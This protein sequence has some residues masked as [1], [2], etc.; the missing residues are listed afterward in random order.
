[1]IEP[2]AHLKK[3]YRVIDRRDS[4][5]GFVRLDRNERT[6]G[7]PEEVL[8]E[9]WA[10][11]TPDFFTAYPQ[12]EPFY[13][14]LAEWLKVD[15]DNLLLSSGSDTAIRHVFETYVEAG[16]EVVMVLPSYDMYPVFCTMYDGIKREIN[17][18]SGFELPINDILNAI[19]PKTKLVALINPN[20]PIIRGYS[21]EELIE[22]I[23]KS[24]RNNAI[25]LIDEAY[26]H[27]CPYTALPLIEKY[28]N[29]VITRT[30]SKAFGIAGLRLGYIISCA[31]NIENMLKVKQTFEVDSFALEVGKYLLEHDSIMKE[32]VAKID[33]G[34]DYLLKELENMSLQTFGGKSNLLLVKLP[35]SV[36][37]DVIVEKLKSKGYLVRGKFNEPPLA[38]NHF[39][40][41]TLGPKEQM[42]GF[43]KALKEV[44]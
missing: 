36:G 32:Y 43:I 33:E 40:R 20:Q 39:I 19:N 25:V 13:L 21:E 26:Y 22:I 9:I 42:A 24:Q 28:D 6:T 7:F 2:R 34:R 38:T 44:Y 11:I 16:D 31:G 4:R 17:F 23:K 15:R 3:V 5:L 37:A 35:D 8:N 10:R 41:I 1:M 12:P 30:F 18:N 27:F 29:L 14:R